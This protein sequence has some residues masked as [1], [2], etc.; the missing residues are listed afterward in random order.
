MRRLTALWL[1]CLW[2]LL[3]L[4][5]A[6][7]NENSGSS[8]AGARREQL[9]DRNAGEAADGAKA[10][11]LGASKSYE[12]DVDA[13]MQA[14]LSALDD[15]E[16]SQQVPYQL[17]NQVYYQPPSLPTGFQPAA[18]VSY[19]NQPGQDQPLSVGAGQ[20]LAPAS[21]MQPPVQSQGQAYAP[22]QGYS[23]SP[24]QVAVPQQGLAAP[25][26]PA[27]PA[28]DPM[29]S[30]A[31]DV[32]YLNAAQPA[33][34]MPS[35]TAAMPA[36]G[37]SGTHQRPGITVTIKP[38]DGSGDADANAVSATQH[39]SKFSLC[40]LMPPPWNIICYIFEFIFFT[41]PM[42]YFWLGLIALFILFRIYLAF[43]EVLDPIIIFI[44]DAIYLVVWCVVRTCQ[45][46]WHCIKVV[47]Y[48]I[49]EKML[50][51]KDTIDGYLN[52]WKRRRPHTHVPGFSY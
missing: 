21:N 43:K 46:I 40:D 24:P 8:D 9:L 1:S 7:A 52:P 48:P 5:G 41:W 38:L 42:Y 6:S 32:P 31:Q 18:S 15:A 23:Q 2:L 27:Y 28:P 51:L 35:V 39:K 25:Q 12:E 3:G 10:A 11:N 13:Q 30:P 37:A 17:P 34:Y 50:G 14:A 26:Q 44:L 29:Q 20:F 36:H 45:A 4:Y 49:K 19:Y 33:Q 47:S 16:S 22:M